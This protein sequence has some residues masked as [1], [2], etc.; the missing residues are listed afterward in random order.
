MSDVCL[1]ETV[2][3]TKP[4]LEEEEEQKEEED[5]L[6]MYLLKAYSPVNRIG[7]PKGFSLD[8]LLHKLN[9]IQNE[10]FIYLFIY[11]CI[12]LRGP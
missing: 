7:S 3:E 12:Y 11:L 8:Q 5:Y 4:T 10:L 9:T 1:Y 6:F 2:N